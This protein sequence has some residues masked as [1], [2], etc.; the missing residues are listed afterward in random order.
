MRKDEPIDEL[1][2]LLAARVTK[3]E[4]LLGKDGILANLF[5]KTIQ[6]MMEGELSESLGYE[7]HRKTDSH[8]SNSRNGSYKKHLQTSGGSVAIDVPRDREGDYAPQILPK[9]QRRTNEI[10]DKIIAMYGRGMSTRDISDMVD[11]MYGASL[12]AGTVSEI[13]NKLLPEIEAWQSRPLEAMY[14][15]LY[16]DAIHVHLR[17]DGQS[18]AR[19][20]YTLLGITLDG[21]KEILGIWVSGESE[22]ANYWLSVLSEIQNRGVKDVLIASVDGLTGFKEAITAVFPETIV[23]RCVVHQI[24]NTLRYVSW[25]DRKDFMRDLKVVYQAASRRE[26][27]LGL[28]QL[29]G[30]WG[31]HYSIAIRSW[32]NNWPELS[33]Y[34]DYPQEIA[35]LIYTTNAIE[36][37]YR[38]MRKVV[39]TKG[40]YT[41]EKALRKQLYLAAMNTSK[42]WTKVMP[43]WHKILNQ[44]MIKFEGRIN[45]PN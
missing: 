16:L 25:K 30:K 33:A 20:V 14:P 29:R 23:Q 11:E 35:R 18:K 34:L 38:Q 28:E 32:E 1:A 12:S 2:K 44:L 3:P 24:R 8:G 39:K 43:D 36:S 41:D 4:D 9:F 15:M 42:K 27:E 40:S 21:M 31:E 45:L 7:K 10:E 17:I 5:G 19:A 26:A 6:T 22:G 37:F 13:T